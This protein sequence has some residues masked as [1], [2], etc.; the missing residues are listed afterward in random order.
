M[1]FLEDSIGSVLPNA[2]ASAARL[3]R[4]AEFIFVSGICLLD[5]TLPSVKDM[6]AD[7][8]YFMGSRLDANCSPETRVL[9]A[10]STRE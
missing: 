3:K 5:S 9:V 10:I 6:A 4:L 7:V 8:R 2:L 1:G